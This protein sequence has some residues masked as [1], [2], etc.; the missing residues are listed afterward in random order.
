MDSGTRCSCVAERLCEIPGRERLKVYP[1]C[2][3][4]TSGPDDL[5]YETALLIEEAE[6][7][8]REH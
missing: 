5:V 2:L 8:I 1:V 3:C 6:R 4:H 7:L